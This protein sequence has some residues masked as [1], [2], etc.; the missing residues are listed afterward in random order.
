MNT[1]L[2]PLSLVD[3]KW[4]IPENIHTQPRSASMFYPPSPQLRKFQNALPAPYAF[5]IP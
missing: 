3:T 5:R 2:H 1:I 4:A